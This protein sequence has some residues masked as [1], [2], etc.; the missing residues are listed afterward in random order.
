MGFIDKLALLFTE[1]NLSSASVD[2][3]LGEIYLVPGFFLY[4]PPPPPPPLLLLLLLF[5]LL[6]EVRPGRGQGTSWIWILEAI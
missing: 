4:S 3:I 1:V 2:T 5:G 6:S